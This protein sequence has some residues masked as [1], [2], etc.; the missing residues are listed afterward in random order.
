MITPVVI[1]FLL[2]NITN[3]ISAAMDI[4]ALTPLWQRTCP[5]LCHRVGDDLWQSG[6]PRLCGFNP[7]QE[8]CVHFM[9]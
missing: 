1:C 3:P 2:G 4:Q 6:P 5:L 8:Q 9:K 7:M